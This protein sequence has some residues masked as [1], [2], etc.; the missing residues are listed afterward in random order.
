MKN[1]NHCIDAAEA[2]I[3]LHAHLAKHMFTGFL[4]KTVHDLRGRPTITRVGQTLDASNR[5]PRWFVGCCTTLAQSWS[6]RSERTNSRTE[7]MGGGGGGTLRD[8][9]MAWVLFVLLII[10]LLAHPPLA[11][12]DF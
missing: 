8:R 1:N 6:R 4:P 7:S 3:V 10:V 2:V 12:S 11:F 9:R 5:E